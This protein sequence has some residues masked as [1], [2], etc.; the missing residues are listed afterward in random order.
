MRYDEVIRFRASADLRRE[1]KAAADNRGETLSRYVRQAAL[2]HA[3]VRDPTQDQK[4]LDELIQ[5][6][7]QVAKMGNNINQIARL[8]NSGRD[9]PEDYADRLT[10]AVESMSER[11]RVA[12]DDRRAAL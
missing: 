7:R 10:S 9:M 1:L 2:A 5:L 6:R 8:T 11:V 12:L 3:R 4:L